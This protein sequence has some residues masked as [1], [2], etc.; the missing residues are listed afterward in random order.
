MYYN[1]FV[2]ADSLCLHLDIGESIFP[3]LGVEMLYQTKGDPWNYQPSGE[4]RWQLFFERLVDDG[5]C[6]A[7]KKDALL[8]W[9][10]RTAFR[11]PL[12][13]KLIATVGN[14]QTPHTTSVLPDGVLVTGLGH[15]KF[16][17]SRW[18]ET[19]AKAY[20]GARYDVGVEA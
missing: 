18:G 5:L 2:F 11:L 17:L 19:N 4:T 10:S 20:F 16:S 12:I 6:L 7:S 14:N 15:I 1:Y 8:T 13:E 3:T 9:P